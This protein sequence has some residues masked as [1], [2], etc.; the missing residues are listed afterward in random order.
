MK[1]TIELTNTD[2]E[3]IKLF[4]E[5]LTKGERNLNIK[6]LEHLHNHQVKLYWRISRELPK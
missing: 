3:T 5:V 6:E 4:D 1:I 2:I